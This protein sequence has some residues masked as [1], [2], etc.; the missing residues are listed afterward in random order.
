MVVE[1]YRKARKPVFSTIL[2]RFDRKPLRNRSKFISRYIG[3]RFGGNNTEKQWRGP[4]MHV[5]ERSSTV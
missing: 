4:Y 2:G 1:V 5:H 3:K